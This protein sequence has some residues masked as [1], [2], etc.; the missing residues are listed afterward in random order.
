MEVENFQ[1]L[2]DDICIN[3][4]CFASFNIVTIDSVSD[5][6]LVYSSCLGFRNYSVEF[7]SDVIL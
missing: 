1:I 4:L 7:G 5:I 2:T 6:K 3:A